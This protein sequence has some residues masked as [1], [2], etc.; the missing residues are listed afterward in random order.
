MK[1]VHDRMRRTGHSALVVMS[2]VE[3]GDVR[4]CVHELAVLVDVTMS[5]GEAL[6]MVVIVV[7]VGVFVLVGVLHHAVPMPVLMR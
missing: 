7:V 3:V 2:V 4:V 6:N 1:D 5:T